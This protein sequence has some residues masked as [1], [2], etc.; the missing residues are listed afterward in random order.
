[1]RALR[2]PLALLAALGFAAYMLAFFLWALAFQSVSVFWDVLQGKTFGDAI[3][4]V[5]QRRAGR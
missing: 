2:L 5:R 3:E 4:L 1:M